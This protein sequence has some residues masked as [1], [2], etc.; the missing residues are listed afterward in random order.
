MKR[1]ASLFTLLAAGV[2]A[3]LVVPTGTA[4]AAP[5]QR[6]ALDAGVANVSLVGA[7]YGAILVKLTDGSTFHRVGESLRV[8]NRAGA[9]TERIDLRHFTTGDRVVP[10]AAAVSADRASAEFVPQVARHTVAQPKKKR[11]TK[12]QAYNDLV[13]KANNNWNCA[14]PSVIGGAVIGGLIG[15]FVI[16]GW[17]PG[18]I[19]GAAIGANNG[20]GA[21]GKGPKRGETVR[22]F[23]TWWNTP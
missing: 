5:A 20:Y 12:A 21:C 11:L 14:A 16:V 19:I 15:L 6:P 7:D 10:M 1:L 22:A 13:A 9:T 23:W 8:V 17:I 2:V 3:L 18:A 4:S